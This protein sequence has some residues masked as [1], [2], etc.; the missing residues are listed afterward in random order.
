MGGRKGPEATEGPDMTFTVESH[1]H[2]FNLHFN[3]H[4]EGKKREHH[5][6]KSLLGSYTLLSLA[7]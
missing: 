6:H 5:V 4:I 1:H 3:T 2:V 7:L